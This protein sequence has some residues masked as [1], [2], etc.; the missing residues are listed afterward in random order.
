MIKQKQMNLIMEN[1]RGFLKEAEEDTAKKGMTMAS[2]EIMSLLKSSE[3]EITKV[4]KSAMEKKAG[5]K[6]DAEEKEGNLQEI[7]DPVSLA[8]LFAGITA[9]MPKILAIFAKI[10]KTESVKKLIGAAKSESA[11]D[12]LK[13]WSHEWHETWLK[14]L[15]D[16]LNV[17]TLFKFRKLPKEKQHKIEE[18]LYIVMVCYLL[19]NA[20]K[21][22][23][24]IL[25]ASDMFGA[26]MSLAEGALSA[27]KSGEILEFLAVNI[28]QVLGIAAG[29]AAG[30]AI[31]AAVS[32]GAI[33]KIEVPPEVVAIG[34]EL[35]YQKAYDLGGGTPE[36]ERKMN[37][38]AKE[39]KAKKL[40]KKE[41]EKALMKKAKFL[42]S[43]LDNGE[44]NAK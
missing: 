41:F 12:K 8:L 14:V 42:R 26:S 2:K 10:A 17:I 29:A 20:I 24:H 7:A 18:I 35:A 39:L 38:F 22:A 15:G 4:S 25:H 37:N 32:T 13:E 16:F 9:S 31:G 33:K 19:G 23:S 43:K 27:I 28:K 21:G 34:A 1:W 3:D 30:A 44:S 36:I 40:P 11:A 6:L 5:K